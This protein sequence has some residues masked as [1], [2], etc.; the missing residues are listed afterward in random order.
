MFKYLPYL[1]TK[2]YSNTDHQKAIGYKFSDL[3]VNKSLH[4]LV[5]RRHSVA[6]LI[7]M[8][9][10]IMYRLVTLTI[11]SVTSFLQLRAISYIHKNTTETKKIECLKTYECFHIYIEKLNNAAKT[12]THWILF[13]FFG[14]GGGGG[15][16]GLAA[17]YS[18]FARLLSSFPQHSFNY[19]CT[20][21]TTCVVY[22]PQYEISINVV[23]ATSKAS[24]Q[25]AHMRSL[26]RVFASHLN[27]I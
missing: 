23:C 18:N 20:Y 26:I 25:P 4:R 2:Y 19:T 21:T 27:I 1:Q 5:L 22:E 9:S 24:D 10:S 8:M 16:G 12:C 13:F 3:L 14:G 6:S 11:D 17:E 7:F 15:G